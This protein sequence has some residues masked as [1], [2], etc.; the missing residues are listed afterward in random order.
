MGFSAPAPSAD[1]TFIARAQSTVV[2]DG[3]NFVSRPVSA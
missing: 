2:I 3:A 1:R